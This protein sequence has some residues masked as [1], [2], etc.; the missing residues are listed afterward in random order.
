M[1]DTEPEAEEV[2]EIEPE[3]DEEPEAPVEDEPTEVEA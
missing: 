3:G 1:S 2:D